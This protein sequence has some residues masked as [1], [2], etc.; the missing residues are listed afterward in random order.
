MSMGESAA[1]NHLTDAETAWDTDV[2]ADVKAHAEAC[3]Q[4]VKADGVVVRVWVRMDLGRGV[5]QQ[6]SGQQMLLRKRR[7]DDLPRPDRGMVGAV[8]HNDQP[9][10]GQMEWC[11]VQM[12]CIISQLLSG[13]TLHFSIRHDRVTAR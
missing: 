13:M 2:K 4:V 6:K 5:C 11:S 9:L 3:I 7:A 12:Q 1:P 8:R 10:D